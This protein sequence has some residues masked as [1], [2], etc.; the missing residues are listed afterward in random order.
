[1]VLG[2][3]HN[4]A[5]SQDWLMNDLTHT[6]PGIDLSEPDKDNQMRTGFNFVPYKTSFT[7]LIKACINEHEAPIS[8]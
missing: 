1:M 7:D 3:G 6:H 8:L 5:C 2:L 4:K